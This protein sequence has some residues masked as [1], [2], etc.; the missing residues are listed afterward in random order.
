[1]SLIHFKYLNQVDQGT[2]VRYSSQL[3]G[4]PATNIQ[5]TVKAKVWRTESDFVVTEYNRGF[6]FRNTST[7]AYKF[8]VASGTYT[9][10]GLASVIE[11][12][13]NSIGIYSDHTCTYNSAT[14]QF[15]VGRTGTAGIFEMSF[16]NPTYR[17]NT[18]AVLMGFEYAT[19]YSGS[20]AYTSTA[21]K[22]NEHE[23]I[24]SFTST[25]SVNTLIID[26][27]NFATGTVIRLRG[28]QGTSTVFSGG[29]NVATAI[30]LSSTLTYNSN[31]I[32]I[33]FTA[34]LIKSMQLYWYDRSQRYSEIGRI[35]AGTYFEPQHRYENDITFRK[36]I[37]QRRSK[38]QLAYSGVTWVDRRTSVFVYEI[39]IDPLDKY[40]NNT[41]KTT[42][43]AMFDYLGVHTPLWISLDTSLNSNTIYGV[44]TNDTEYERLENTPVLEVGT[45]MIR[46][47][48]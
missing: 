41:T 44:L 21:T 6:T 17:Y 11:S 7:I 48:K 10:S 9:G 42:F 33:E 47:Q 39:G 40:Y 31:I 27:H 28:T 46:E 5:N 12:N 19:N 4:L 34:T 14:Q 23:I 2:V 1:M 24:V 20:F 16:N 36:K 38:Q 45:I 3:A 43:E 13:L 26:K 25:Q 37:I 32:S 35:F 29:W 15:H 22:G 18:V 30:S 8:S